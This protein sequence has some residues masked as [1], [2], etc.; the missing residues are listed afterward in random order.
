ML[1]RRFKVLKKAAENL[2]V[3]RL[4][5]ALDMELIKCSHSNEDYYDVATTSSESSYINI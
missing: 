1:P 5:D 3:S 2:R 4:I